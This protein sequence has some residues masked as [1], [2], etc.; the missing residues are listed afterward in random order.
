[1][2]LLL[3]T[4]LAAC[5]ATETS[6]QPKIALLAPFEG[7]YREVGYNALY[8][9]RLAFVDAEPGN[10]QLLAVDDGGTVASA[11]A[12]I[13]A[14][15]MDP[16]VEAI[17]ALGPAATHSAVQTANDNPLVLIGNWGHDRADEDA[18]YAANPDLAKARGSG[19]L[20]ALYQ[21]IDLWSDLESVTFSSSGSLPDAEFRERFLNSALYAPPP[22]LLATLTYDIARMALQA[23]TEDEALGTTTFQGMNAAIRFKDGY[24]ANAPVKRYRYE[25]DQ[26][27]QAAT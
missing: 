16:A 9:L 1:M 20:M 6:P 27:V 13:K 18:L 4:A 2:L 12:R 7:K 22:N 11:V 10:A 17:I 23:L 3:S 14:L 19:D 8:A 25:G 15:N 5:A 21:T 24:W 26:L